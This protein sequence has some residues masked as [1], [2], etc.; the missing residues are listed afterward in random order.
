MPKAARVSNTLLYQ[1]GRVGASESFRM[2]W[3]EGRKGGVGGMGGCRIALGSGDL[4][5][6]DR[7]HFGSYD[8]PE[9]DM[10]G[11]NRCHLVSYF[12]WFTLTGA[13]ISTELIV[14]LN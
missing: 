9:V 12:G 2:L 11:L 5:M 1:S 8:C 10:P 7:C 6:I 3:G 4:G 13:R 14:I